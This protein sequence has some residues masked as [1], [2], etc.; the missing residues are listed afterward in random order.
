MYFSI[1]L[2]LYKTLRKKENYSASLMGT[3]AMRLT[4]A[5]QTTATR[6]LSLSTTLTK[7]TATSAVIS[8]PCWASTRRRFPEKASSTSTVI[9]VTMV[10]RA[11]TI[12]NVTIK[13]TPVKGSIHTQR[14]DRSVQDMRIQKVTKRESNNV[15]VADLVLGRFM[16][17]KGDLTKMEEKEKI[18]RWSC[19]LYGRWRWW[20]RIGTWMEFGS[21]VLHMGGFARWYGP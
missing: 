4:I 2:S 20:S 7:C 6:P 11:A 5:A 14:A 10:A 9:H 3:M 16:F 8:L 21:H 12:T 13:A 19:L 18:W 1:G 17:V 15:A